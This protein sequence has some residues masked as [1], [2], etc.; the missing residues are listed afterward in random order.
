MED[1]RGRKVLVLGLART[2]R[3][4]AVF[5]AARGARVVAVDERADVDVSG[6]PPEV[7][8]HP[9]GTWPDPADFDL[10]VPSPGVPH[11]RYAARA[12]RAWGDLEI[13]WRALAVPIVAV[14]GTN[15]KSTTV[16]LVEAMLR[17]AGLRAAAAGNVGR[18][19]LELV[20]E[21]LD[22]AVLEVS[23]FQLEAVEGFRP[24]VAALLNVTDD[25]LDRHGSLEAYLAAKRRIFARQG[26]GD[27]AVLAA[28]DPRV[29]A[30]AGSLPAERTLLFSARGPCAEGAFLDGDRI[31]LQ[32]DGRA[33]RLDVPGGALPPAPV[34]DDVLA[35][36]LA[37]V[38][39]GAD[40]AAA[41]GALVDFRPLPH[42]MEPVRVRG[43]VRFVNDSKATN[44]G[45]AEAALRGPAGP[46]VWLAGGR[47][48]GLDFRGLA[49]AARGRVRVALL[50]G[51]A[52][53]KLAAA[54]EGCVPT[55]RV[56][57]L[58]AAVAR[59]AALARPGET[60][61]LAPA[62]ASFDQFR[63]YEARGERFRSLVAGLPGAGGADAGPEEDA[64]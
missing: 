24:R 21:A 37:A 11:A 52:A 28:D 44:P 59:A 16:R 31:V 40:P 6:L 5:L 19:A 49:E 46:V 20:G 8:V 36:L 41:L 48:K 64:S 58:D 39:A 18:P 47:D 1:L 42:R 25:H 29:A 9:G 38:A 13:A 62:S 43:G 4:A 10:V 53:P 54:L 63:D 34:R 32:R 35:A 26:E 3:S 2:G 15:G 50:Y 17:A 12:R 7:E 23:S 33:T 55:E 27:T 14:T 30:L 22:V 45:A 51:E 60:V 56:P 61:L 57:D